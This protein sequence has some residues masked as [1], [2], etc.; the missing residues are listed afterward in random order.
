MIKESEEVIKVR[1][2]L[3]EISEYDYKCKELVRELYLLGYEFSTRVTSLNNDS[4]FFKAVKTQEV[5]EKGKRN[6]Y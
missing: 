5:K 3:K 2:I 6:E 1:D 4:Y